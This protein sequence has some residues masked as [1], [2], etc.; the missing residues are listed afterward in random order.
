MALRAIGYALE[1]HGIRTFEL[2]LQGE[3]Y[4]VRSERQSSKKSYM[5]RF[6][7]K[8]VE[9]L[10]EIFI[11]RNPPESSSV[12]L[13][14]IYTPDDIDRLHDEGCLRRKDGGRP[15]PHSLPQALRGIGRH[16]DNEGARLG[17]ISR[18]GPLITVQY[19]TARGYITEEFAPSSLY[20]LFVRMYVKRSD[21]IKD[22]HSA[23]SSSAGN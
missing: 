1:A 10:L 21:R 16:I 15:D 2:T 8:R 13:Q 11:Y 3:N 17:R 6:L 23:R 18:Y 12:G 5:K 19:E 7:E 9:K 20:A 22:I 4:I 14:L